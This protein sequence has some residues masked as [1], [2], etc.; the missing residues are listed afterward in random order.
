MTYFLGEMAWFSNFFN[1]WHGLLK[2][3]HHDNWYNLKEYAKDSMRSKRP[4]F[5]HCYLSDAAPNHF[6]QSWLFTLGLWFFTCPFYSLIILSLHVI[7]DWVLLTCQSLL[8]SHNLSFLICLS[9]P[10]SLDLTFL[11]CPPSL[12]TL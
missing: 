2:H 12:V 6:C 10:L 3:V 5:S 9:R 7:L 4:K 11:T 8:F 1:F